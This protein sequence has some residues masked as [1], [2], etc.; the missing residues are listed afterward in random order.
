MSI[1]PNTDNNHISDAGMKAFSTTDHLP[2]LKKLSLCTSFD[3]FREEWDH[4]CW[5]GYDAGS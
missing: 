4:L 5:N 3:L 2:Q 1:S